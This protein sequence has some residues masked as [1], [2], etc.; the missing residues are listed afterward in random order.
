MFVWVTQWTIISLVLICLLHYLYFFFIDTL[1]VPKIRDLI[2]KPL[3]RYN[4]IS[5][6]TSKEPVTD[7]MHNELR[8]FLN[9][10]SSKEPVD[11]TPIANDTEPGVYS[12]F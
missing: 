9:N 6:L 3:E 12:N 8:Q 2:H 7:D 5:S 11:T 1:T 4:E 10:I